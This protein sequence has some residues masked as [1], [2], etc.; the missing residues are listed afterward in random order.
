M[1][2][3]LQSILLHPHGFLPKQNRLKDNV[4]EKHDNALNWNP[5]LTYGSALY[6]IWGEKNKKQITFFLC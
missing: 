6:S 4:K 1:E 2:Q 3:Y 5:I